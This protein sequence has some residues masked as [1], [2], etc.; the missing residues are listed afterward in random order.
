MP[1]TQA[2]APVRNDAAA[3]LDDVSLTTEVKAS[4]SIDSESSEAV[5]ATQLKTILPALSETDRRAVLV[6]LRKT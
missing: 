5:E 1:E 6:S 4:A 2:T 3:F